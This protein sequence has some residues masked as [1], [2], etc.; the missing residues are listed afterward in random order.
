MNRKFQPAATLFAI[1][2]LGLGVLAIIFHDFALVWQPVEPTVPGRTALA[3]LSGVV[4]LGCG[5]GLLFRATTAW[6][7][8]ILFPYVFIWMLL[9]VPALFAA[10]GMEAVWLG[11]GE[12]VMLMAGGWILWIVL[13]ESVSRSV[14]LIG[15][16]TGL[17]RAV[18]AFGLALL[19]IGLSHLVYIPETV[20]FIPGWLP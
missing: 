19:P 2:L 18:V 13:D 6:A 7:T 11:F 12:V 5:V 8:R 4:M 17:H 9:K 16:S 1:G 20:G 3:Y 10:P 15:G 14:P